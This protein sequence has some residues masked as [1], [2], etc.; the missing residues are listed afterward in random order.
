MFERFSK[1]ARAVIVEALDCAVELGSEDVG[2]GHL[3][4]G[5]AVGS[6]ETAA[7]PLRACGITAASVRRLLSRTAK[8]GAG[9]DL[10]PL[11][12]IGI[13]YEAVRAAVE[14]TFGPGSLES[15]ADRRASSRGLRRPPFSS[16]AKR[17]LQL[18]LRVAVELHDKTMVPGH[19]LLG[20]L[21]LDNE[22]VS[23]AVE[24]SG[25]TVAGLSAVILDK[26]AAAA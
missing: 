19:L 26:V 13:D 22:F 24:R 20:L 14:K 18:G 7:E 10:E 4:Y 16:E 11:R 6:E 5:C 15:A 21:R 8:R 12:A 3:L 17:S 1:E 9:E 23:M 2:P 25:T